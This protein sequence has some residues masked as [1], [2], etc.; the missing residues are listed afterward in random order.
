MAKLTEYPRAFKFDADDIL[1]KDGTNGTHKITIEDVVKELGVM[2]ADDTLLE[3]GKLAPADKV[4]EE[5]QR[6]DNKYKIVENQFDDIVAF[7]DGI[8]GERVESLIV[9]IEPAQ[10][11]SESPA[12]AENV[13]PITGHTGV[14]IRRTGLNMWGGDDFLNDASKAVPGRVNWTTRS[15]SIA[16]TSSS[17]P[18]DRFA[19]IYPNTGRY[20]GIRLDGSIYTLYIGLSREDTLDR[21]TNL[22][23]YRGPLS[24]GS[25]ILTTNPPYMGLSHTGS[26]F[27]V[28]NKRNS[29]TTILYADKVALLK[30]SFKLEEL[31]VDPVTKDIVDP[32]KF[33]AYTCEKL[34]IDWETVAGTVYGGE[35]N[36]LTGELKVT[37]GCYESYAGE[38]LPGKWISSMDV[39]AQGSV[40]TIG[41]KVVYELSSPINYLLAPANLTTLEGHNRIWANTGKISVGVHVD[42]KGYIDEVG[43]AANRHTDEIANNLSQNFAEVLED[44]VAERSYN[45]GEFIVINSVL[46]KVTSPV[47]VEET[48]QPGV[49]IIRTTV[50]EELAAI[51]AAINP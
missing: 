49:N 3:E 5:I 15:V 40:P 22:Y 7:D 11:L 46:Y 8:A 21:K 34:V 16:T 29:G 32:S 14:E 27:S 2:L 39:Y 33:P 26:L 18:Q 25:Q 38:A 44:A 51:W 30:G 20:N 42:L 19:G 1:V 41:S 43:N 45:I 36:V 47:A 31:G 35:L 17:A 6:L 4:G 23:V 37:H 10:K 9:K 13:L 28:G 12:S 48:F 50:G 24:A